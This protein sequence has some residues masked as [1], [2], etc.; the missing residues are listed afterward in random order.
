LGKSV[1]EAG[2]E[3]ARR[4]SRVPEAGQTS[5]PIWIPSRTLRADADVPRMALRL[6]EA[7]H[8]VFGRRTRRCGRSGVSVGT[9]PGF[10]ELSDSG[11]SGH[12]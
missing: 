1:F 9:Q 12:R 11:T 6:I 7:G 4:P 8:L 2:L 5:D 3:P 10:A